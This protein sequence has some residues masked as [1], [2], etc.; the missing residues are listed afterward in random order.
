MRFWGPLGCLASE[1]LR[2]FFSRN[3]PDS[4]GTPDSRRIRQIAVRNPTLSISS[5]RTKES[6]PSPLTLICP[7]VL[8]RV[9]ASRS[10]HADIAYLGLIWPS[11][12]SLDEDDAFPLPLLVLCRKPDDSQSDPNHFGLTAADPNDQG[13]SRRLVAV[14]STR[15]AYQDR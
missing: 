8:R 2:I 12:H 7:Q 15:V 11:P 4:H 6:L 10:L 3:S 1:R 9:A 13:A 14:I 5:P